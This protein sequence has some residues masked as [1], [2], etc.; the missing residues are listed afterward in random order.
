MRPTLASL[1]ALLAA[2][3]AAGCLRPFNVNTVDRIKFENPITGHFS[4]EIPPVS[5]PSPVLEVPVGGPKSCKGPKVALIDVDG[6]LVDE[7]LT[8]LLSLGENPVA[9]FHE[10]LQA[11]AADPNVGAV[12]VRINSPGGGVAA[13]EMMW[14]ELQTFRR[15]TGRP[16]VACLMDLGTGGAYLLATAADRI[17]A[18]PATVTGGVGVIINLYNLIDTMQQFNVRYQPIKSGPNIDMGTVTAALTP[19]AKKQLQAMADEF[20][21]R[22]QE[23]VRQGRPAL[24]PGQG[25]TLDGRVFTARQAQERGLIDQVGYLDDAVAGAREL[26]GQPGAGVVMYRRCNDPA[27]SVYAISPNTPMQTGLVP[28]SVPG[29]DR[30]RLPTFLYLWQPEPTLEKLSGR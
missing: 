20:H 17:V 19:E 27:R 3:T 13:S 12:V 30:S 2:L 28:V 21:Q 11:A 8:G 10:K 7:N 14:K 24:N 23:A 25:A 15:D 18:H 9:L 22:F 29:L 5:N 26:A 4:A 1:A 16:V 6:L